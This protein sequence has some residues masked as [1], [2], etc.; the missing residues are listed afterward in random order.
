LSVDD[1]DSDFEHARVLLLNLFLLLFLSEI[2]Y[3]RIVFPDRRSF[4]S[5]GSAE[6]KTEIKLPEIKHHQRMVTGHKR[7]QIGSTRKGPRH[8]CIEKPFREVAKMIVKTISIDDHDHSGVAVSP[9]RRLRHDNSLRL[10]EEWKREEYGGIK[11]WVNQFTGDVATENPFPSSSTKKPYSFSKQNS[12][13]A[14]HSSATHNQAFKELHHQKSK[15]KSLLAPI[16]TACSY[17]GL[18]SSGKSPSVV[19]VDSYNNGE[20]SDLFRMLDD[21]KRKY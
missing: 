12:S 18:I 20:M 17:K 5:I 11:M 4:L 15:S 13:S 21:M 8:Q 2:V 7:V 19:E 6:S 14:K 9:A 1:A 3:Y 16:T 10:I